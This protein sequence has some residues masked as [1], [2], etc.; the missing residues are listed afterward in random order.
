MTNQNQDLKFLAKI[1]SADK[2]RNGTVEVDAL[3][4][5]DSVVLITLSTL[6]VFQHYMVV[7]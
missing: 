5:T 7:C 4:G 2:E 1:F 6:A 3:N